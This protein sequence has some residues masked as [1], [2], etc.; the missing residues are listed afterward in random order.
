M[1]YNLIQCPHRVTMDIFGDPTQRDEI[2]PFVQLLWE[3]GQLFERETIQALDLPFTDLKGGSAAEREA[4]TTDAMDRGDALIYGGRISAD[5]L[6]GEPDLLRRDGDKYVAGDIKSGAGEEGATEESDGKPKPHY[7]VQLALYTDILERLGRSAGRR[8]FV[9]DVHGE[10]VVY[11]L[12]ALQGV[13]TP[14]ALWTTYQECLAEARR[15]V[16]ESEATLPAL[17]G[18]CKLCQWKTTCKARLET[19]DDLTLIPD[20][21]RTKRDGMVALIPTVRAMATVDVA[22]LTRG[23]K[24]VIVGVGPD[25]LVKFQERARLLVRDDAQPYL[26]ASLDLPSSETELFFD[27]EN[28]PFR[29]ICYLHGFVER[30]GGPTGT[31]RFVACLAEQPTPGEERRAFSEAWDYVTRSRPCAIYYYSSHEKTVWRKLQKRFPE[32]ATEAD[33]EEM[34]AAQTSIDL[35]RVVTSKSVWPT[36]DHSIKTLATHIGFTWRDAEPSGA[37]SIEWYHRWVETGDP[38]LRQ[39]IL[40]YNE[41]DCAAMRALLDR[42]RQLRVGPVST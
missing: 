20:L 16:A 39:R 19:L 5:D 38:A 14:T 4:L 27:I 12:D 21:G 34:F 13:R 7:A 31:E 2:S 23:K 29:D 3:K 10:E 25:S 33:I 1:L 32:V 6:V 22:S 18:I 40:D 30:R 11:D 8:P 42:L 26:K 35:Y 15:I 41:D 9:W 36:R 24:T 28:D 37:A 17:S